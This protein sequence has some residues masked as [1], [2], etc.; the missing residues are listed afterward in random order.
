MAYV[1]QATKDHF[2]SKKLNNTHFGIKFGLY[3]TNGYHLKTL[4]TLIVFVLCTL[5]E[6]F[7]FCI[8]KATKKAR[9]TM[10]RCSLYTVFKL[11]TS[12]LSTRQK[13][14]QLNTSRMDKIQGKR[15]QLLKSKRTA[16]KKKWLKF[17]MNILKAWEK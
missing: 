7:F 11:T 14:M 3:V 9:K 12:A 4:H 10:P 15:F 17:S 5:F 13:L 16:I 1:N 6:I 8:L 2:W